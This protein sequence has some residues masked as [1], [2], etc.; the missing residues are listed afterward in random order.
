MWRQACGGRVE[1]SDVP[2]G[3]GQTNLSQLSL[4]DLD[5]HR[6]EFDGIDVTPEGLRVTD[7]ELDSAV[8]SD[9]LGT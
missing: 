4:L 7:D 8:V 3:S 6:D 9:A 2:K 1:D 5:P